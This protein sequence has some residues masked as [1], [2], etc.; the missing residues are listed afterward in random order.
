MIQLFDEDYEL[1]KKGLSVGTAVSS[2]S[3]S[4]EGFLDGNVYINSETKDV[5][6]CDGTSWVK[7]GNLK[8]IS[9]IRVNVSTVD[10]GNNVVTITYTDGSQYSFNVKNGSKGSQGTSVT[11]AVDNGDG[12]FYL[13]L[14]NGSKTGNVKTI[15]GL[16][17]DKGDKGNKGD[18]GDKGRS[19]DSF[20]MSGTGKQ[21]QITA[22]FSDGTTQLIGIIND[23]ND[24]EGTG[25]M[26]KATYDANNN[27]IV[28]RAEALTDGI[29]TIPAEAVMNKADKANTLS[30][31][32]ITDAYTKSQIN[33]MLDELPH[34]WPSLTEKPFDSLGNSFATRTVGD[35]NVLGLSDAVNNNLDQ[36]DNIVHDGFYS[37]NLSKGLE[38]GTFNNDDGENRDSEYY[39]RLKGFIPIVAEKYT[40]SF[41]FSEKEKM[42]LYI[43]FYSDDG[44]LL[45]DLAFEFYDSG[46]RSFIPPTNATKIRV[47]FNLRNSINQL[48]PHPE[49][50]ISDVQL[51]EGEY[52]IADLYGLKILDEEDNVIGE[53]TEVYQTGANDVYEI[54]KTDG[55]TVLIPAIA[56]CVLDVNIEEGTMK[57]HILEGL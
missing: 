25:D 33:N 35:S 40:L 24:G 51:E 16:K 1:V 22:F 57:V 49:N 6:K 13:T 8:S 18:T 48:Y 41:K 37:R 28:D 12:S 3:S 27:G 38:I 39:A 32:G 52:Y 45:N 46:S 29:N 53:L 47:R 31:Y 26:L 14:S 20:V 21:H 9:D 50:Y 30:G 36:V 34:D 10:D 23:G 56:Q 7:V 43:Y 4:V 54:L 2:S 15:Q 42:G 44:S 5:F 11:G 55:K 19:V 17:G